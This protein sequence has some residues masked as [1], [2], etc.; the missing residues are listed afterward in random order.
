[1]TYVRGLTV[2]TGMARF[3]RTL[4]QYLRQLERT[5]A[6]SANASERG[7]GAK[8]PYFKGESHYFFGFLGARGLAAFFLRM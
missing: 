8:S 5:P 3:P 7:H 4:R 1:M 6:E 2:V